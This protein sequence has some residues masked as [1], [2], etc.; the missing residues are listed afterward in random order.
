MLELIFKG[1]SI[2][3]LTAQLQNAV[4]E[5]KP[6]K[7][8]ISKEL[9]KSEQRAE[10]TTS[11]PSEQLMFPIDSQSSEVVSEVQKVE[12]VKAAVK[13]VAKKAPVKKAAK[14]EEV[15]EVEAE[16]EVV[17][18]VTKDQVSDILRTVSQKHGIDRVMKLLAG[19]KA[20]AV[21]DLKADQYASFVAECKATLV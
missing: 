12:E 13:A 14:V 2:Q 6:Q 3:E 18:K 8:D 21:K 4:N 19:Y 1:N 20:R 15:V 10:Q 5:L 16:E 17:E 9:K 11:A 7:I